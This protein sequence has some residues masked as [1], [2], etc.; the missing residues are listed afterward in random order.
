[1][2]CNLLDSM[3]FLRFPKFVIKVT[4]QISAVN[5]GALTVFLSFGFQIP[6]GAH[7]RGAL[8]GSRASV[9][10]FEIQNVLLSNEE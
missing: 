6:S 3:P 2:Q 1:M 10:L 8:A 7:A 4:N 9:V 5:G